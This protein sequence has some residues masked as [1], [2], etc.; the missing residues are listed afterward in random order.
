[1]ILETQKI[2]ANCLEARDKVAQMCKKYEL[3]L[4]KNGPQVAGGRVQKS[5]HGNMEN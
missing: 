5:E 1:M 2:K 3:I 4:V